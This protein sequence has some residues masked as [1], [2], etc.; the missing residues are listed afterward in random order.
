MI[1]I[2]NIHHRVLEIGSL[3]IVPGVTSIIGPNGSGKTT[4]LKLCAGITEPD[5]GT[6]LVDGL[7]MRTT[8]AGWVDEFPDRNILFDTVVDEI[9]SPLRFRRVSC[10]AISDLIDSHLEFTGIMSLRDRPM[11]EL[12]GGEKIL[13]A[14]AAALVHHPQAACPR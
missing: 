14:L 7:P 3:D 6:V 1:S 13:V 10:R 8:E 9:A 11:R 5:E 12:S 4:L 2:R